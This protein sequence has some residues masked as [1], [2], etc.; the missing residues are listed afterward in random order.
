MKNEDPDGHG[1]YVRKVAERTQRYTEELMTDN[2]QLRLRVAELESRNGELANAVDRHRREQD[3]LHESI[4]LV[5]AESAQFAERYRELEIQNS[6]LASLYVASYRLHGTLD[7]DEV[8]SAIQ[9][10]VTNLVGCEEMAIL[11]MN[12]AGTALALA[13][14]TGID[15][16][17]YRDIPVGQGRIGACALEGETFVRRNEADA[18]AD[19][20]EAAL[21]ACVPF[22]LD[23]KVSAVLALFRLL[24]QKVGIEEL[25]RELFDLLATHA[26]TALYCTALHARRG[27]RS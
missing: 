22:K 16:A 5:Q 18:P 13:A 10:I 15:P 21:S 24:P 4:R 23:G 3:L 25:D 7:R 2:H 27:E 19:E 11:E 14:S 8:L 12:D 17:L 26:S 6:N 1:A 20:R 9:E